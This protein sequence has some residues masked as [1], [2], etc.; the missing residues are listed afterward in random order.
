MRGFSSGTV[1]KNL[2][3]S[4]GDTRKV[5]STPGSGR[6]PGIGNGNLLQDSCLENSINRGAWLTII[7]GVAKSQT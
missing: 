7:H 1:V 4:T 6:S 3:A 2:L 5:G